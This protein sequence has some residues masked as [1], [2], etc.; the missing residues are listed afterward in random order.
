MG[1][2]LA[3]RAAVN[4][5][6]PWPIAAPFDQGD[7]SGLMRIEPLKITER[8]LHAPESLERKG[9]CRRRSRMAVQPDLFRCDSYNELSE[10]WQEM[11]ASPRLG[12][13][14]TMDRSSSLGWTRELAV[15]RGCRQTGTRLRL[16]E[17]RSKRKTGKVLEFRAWQRLN[18]QVRLGDV[19]RDGWLQK[20][21]KAINSLGVSIVNLQAL[22]GSPLLIA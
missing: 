16:R 7:L 8:C 18:I 4:G 10:I 2:T 12:L 17:N 3:R 13:L 19:N 1:Q 14:A 6:T 5:R 20:F 9:V 22:R 11:Q 15:F 21:V